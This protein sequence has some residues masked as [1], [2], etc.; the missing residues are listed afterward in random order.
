MLET[1]KYANFL[2]MDIHREYYI[3]QCLVDNRL[4]QIHWSTKQTTL[5]NEEY[6]VVYSRDGELI[7][8]DILDIGSSPVYIY[9]KDAK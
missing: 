3:L 4:L 8:Q 5:R 7:T 6:F 1:L 2:R 9:I